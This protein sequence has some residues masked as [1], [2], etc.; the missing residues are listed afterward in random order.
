[1]FLP[2]GDTPNPKGVPFVTYLLI[3]ANVAVFLLFNIPLG[4][5]RA[6]VSD[7]AFREYVQV[8]AQQVD[9]RAE[10]RQLIA[11][12]SKFDLFA[13]THGYRPASPQLVDLLSC[14]FLHGGFMHLAGNMLFLWIYG[15]N[16][17]RR[18]G[19]IPYLVAYLV[20]GVLATLAHA[21]VF[22]SSEMP[23][24]GASGAI[25]GILGFYFVFFPRNSVRMLVFL[26]PFLMQ[27]LLLP[28]RWVLGAFVVL[29]NLLPF[30]FA[31]EGGVAHGAHLG[32]F[33]AGAATALFVERWR[34]D[35]RPQPIAVDAEPAGTGIPRGTE[36]LRAALD[37]GRYDQAARSYFALP[38]ASAR[39][40]VSPREA[41]ALAGWLR[42]NGRSDA[43]L[44]LL[45]RVVRDSQA[46]EGLAQAHALAGA[47]LLE[48]MR[49][50]TAAYQY[51]LTALEL[52]P[53][54]ATRSQLRAHLAEI[55][56][57]Q[58]RRIGR[59]HAPTDWS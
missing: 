38:P 36:A 44:A 8:M 43:A 23:L 37:A 52:D 27:V 30:L 11:R 33:L 56:A 48:D 22:A 5:Q 53:D 34:F 29:D 45:R 15:D 31:G 16:V 25:S 59:L 2:I 21:L 1:M 47:I 39:S 54:P 7:P 10:L 50:P 55:E 13:F 14:M 42:E 12:T 17:E 9:N 28:A 24:V 18:L 51:L 3:A 6:D 35:R 49:E 46:G 57:L 19:A 4:S 58:K 40:A 41:V 32:G 20:T 26:P